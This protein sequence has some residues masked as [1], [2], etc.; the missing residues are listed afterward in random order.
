MAQ[1]DLELDTTI[2]SVFASGRRSFSG[3]PGALRERLA[4]WA[5]SLLWLLAAA[6]LVVLW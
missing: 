5:L 6:V 1:V 3:R 2:R 4:A